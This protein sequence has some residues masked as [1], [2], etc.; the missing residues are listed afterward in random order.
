MRIITFSDFK[1]HTSPLFKC[2]NLLKLS[3]V[4]DVHT[5][6]FMHQYR[7]GIFP[8]L[9]S[10]FFTPITSKHHYGTRLASE[11][12]FSLPSARTNYGKFNIRFCGP[13][14][15]NSI[16]ESLKSLSVASFKRKLKKHIIANY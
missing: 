1:A 7:N 9:F 14:A 16:D 12:N 8:D 15:R 13:K 3:D 11:S 5:A 10:I 2:L 6:Q 4:V